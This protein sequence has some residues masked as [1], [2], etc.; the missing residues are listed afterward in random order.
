MLFTWA[1]SHFPIGIGKRKSP[2]NF[3]SGGEASLFTLRLPLR[4]GGERRARTVELSSAPATLQRVTN[5]L[6]IRPHV[7]LPFGAAE[8]ERGWYVGICTGPRGG[9]VRAA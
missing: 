6:H 4:R 2:S 5:L 1:R 8:Q 9:S 3:I 7:L